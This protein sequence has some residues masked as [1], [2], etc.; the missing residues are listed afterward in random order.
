M[1]SVIILGACGR[2]GSALSKD[3]YKKKYNLILVDNNK[4]KLQK[5]KN[6]FGKKNIFFYNCDITKSKNIDNLIKFSLKKVLSINN[7]VVCSY[8]KNSGFGKKFEKLDEISLK[9]TLWQQLGSIIMMVQKFSNIF[10]KNK[11]GNLIFLSSIMGLRTPK[12]WHYNKLNMTSPVE[13]VAV[14]SAIISITSYFSKYFKGYNLRFN[15]ISPGGIKDQQPKKFKQRYK[16]SCLSKGLLNS[17][18]LIGTINFLLSDDSKYING[19]NIIVDDG[20]SL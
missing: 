17:E 12:F 4:P 18:D 1:K 6:Y 8:P 16:Q 19:Q 9:T 15:C 20:W 5:M 2:I 10:K 13:Y 3:L 14:K 11:S 7:V